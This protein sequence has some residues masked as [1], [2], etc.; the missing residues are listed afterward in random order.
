MNFMNFFQ[1]IGP[2]LIEVSEVLGMIARFVGEAALKFP[3][4]VEFVFQGVLAI[5]AKKEELEA[6]GAS[7]EEVSLQVAS[8]RD[9]LEEQTLVEFH[10]SGPQVNRQF[11]KGLIEGVVAMVKA[12]KF[13]IKKVIAQEEKARALGYLKSPDLD[14]AYNAM[15][16]LFGKR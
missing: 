12:E 14:A 1:K 16:W 13:G 6:S 4:V 7:P 11:V 10:G 2:W 5:F 8:L 9:E 15:P 3:A